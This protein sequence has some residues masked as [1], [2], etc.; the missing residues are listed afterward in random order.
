MGNTVNIKGELLTL[1]GSKNTD[2]VIVVE[3]N[4]LNQVRRC[5]GTITA[6]SG[7]AGYDIGASYVNTS[8]GAVYRNTGTTASC[9]FTLIGTVGAGGVALANLAAGITPSHVVKFAGKSASETDADASI[10]ITVTGAV[11]AT[12][13]AQAQMVAGANAVYV[14]RTVVTTDTVTVTLSGN[15]GAGTIVSYV[16]YRAAA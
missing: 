15:G 3:K 13:F 10:V 9:T 8:T 2:G 14:T 4:E 6:P 11:A 1:L 12:D 16:V 5:E 7:K